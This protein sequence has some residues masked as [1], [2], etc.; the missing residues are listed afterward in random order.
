MGAYEVHAAA[1]ARVLGPRARRLGFLSG[2]VTRPLKGLVVQPGE[3][4]TTKSCGR[5]IPVVRLHSWPSVDMASLDISTP[6]L[7]LCPTVYCVRPGVALV[8]S[9]SRRCSVALV[10]AASRRRGVALVASAN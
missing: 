10:A 9:A 4:A 6:P 3:H 7:V 5:V 8:A 2:K 1:C